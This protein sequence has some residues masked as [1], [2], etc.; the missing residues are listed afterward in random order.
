MINPILSLLNVP[1]IH[2]A[3]Q[4]LGSTESLFGHLERAP[5]VQRVRRGRYLGELTDAH[6]DEAI[7]RCFDEFRKGYILP[8]QPVIC[9]L[10][11]ALYQ[12]TGEFVSKL[13]DEA[14]AQNLIET[15]LIYRVA[16]RC[17]LEREALQLDMR[18]GVH[19]RPSSTRAVRGT[20]SLVSDRGESF[21]LGAN[22]D[23]DIASRPLDEAA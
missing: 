13:F 18:I 8:K 23:Y 9:A 16:K 20:T 10:L 3:A 19:S 6:V 17:Q 4:L 14:V 21:K 11:V 15:K 2:H 5:Q 1:D 12:E 7:A 22:S